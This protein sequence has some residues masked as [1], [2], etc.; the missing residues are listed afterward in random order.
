MAKMNVSGDVESRIKS[1]FSIR[2]HNKGSGDASQH[3]VVN[4]NGK[5]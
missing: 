1:E 3:G 2:Q 5:N 4:W